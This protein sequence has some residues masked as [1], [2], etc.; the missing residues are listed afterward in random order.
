MYRKEYESHE[1]LAEND[2][3]DTAPV[4]RSPCNAFAFHEDQVSI[5]SRFSGPEGR[6]SLIA[7]LSRQ[8]IV[9]GQR[10]AVEDLASVAIIEEYVLGEVLIRQGDVDNDLLFI[11]AGRVRILV[12]GRRVAHREADTHV[13]E[14]CVLDPSACRTATV[15]ATK[16]TVVA[17]IPQPQFSRIAEENPQLWQGIAIELSRRLEQRGKF[18]QEPNPTPILFVGSSK[19]TL[20]VA[21]ALCGEIP[22]AVATT[23]LWSDGV[24]MPSRF[25][26]EDLEA[27]LEVA[28]FAV[29]VAGPDDYVRSR[30]KAHSAPRDNIILEL[31]LFM[32]AL[33]R[34]RTFLIVPNGADLKIP[35][36]LLG[37]THLRYNHHEPPLVCDVTEARAQL[38]TTM[39]LLGSK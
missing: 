11:L 24:F 26:I 21:R 31:G 19:E 37:L 17:R 13:G 5:V 3:V 2:S 10:R 22:E 36:D 33:S 9:Q 1:A 7:S 15:I 12:N 39:R 4:S 32:G 38:V 34:R 25:P 29:L 8:S 16:T 27:K 35:S 20:P 6:P 18:H 28:D 14:I 30:G 23:C